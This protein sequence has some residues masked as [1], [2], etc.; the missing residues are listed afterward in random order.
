MLLLLF[1]LGD[2]R[3]AIP[4]IQVAEVLP[5]PLLQPVEQAPQGVVGLFRYR[6][7][8]LPLVDLK[9]NQHGETCAALMSSR[10]IVVAGSETDSAL[11]LLAEGVTETR[12]A[13][14]SLSL[15]SLA[16]NNDG[17]L[18]PVL[19]EDA[20]GLTRLVHWQAL[21]TPELRRLIAAN[22]GAT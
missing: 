2:Q 22:Q 9:L 6:G 7:Q 1:R 5:L 16:G 20:E 21:L 13:D 10:V 14:A 15:P 19:F 18:E 11:G 3:Y 12:A 4:A 17:W 8:W